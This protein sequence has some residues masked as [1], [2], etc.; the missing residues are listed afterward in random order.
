[1]NENYQIYEEED[2][3]SI[4]EIFEALLKRIKLIIISV[5]IFTLGVSFFVFFVSKPSYEAKVKI[6]AGKTEQVQS[7]YSDKELESYSAI[8]NTYIGLIKTE[9]F[10]SKIINKT[11]IDATPK[12]L[13]NSLQFITTEDTPI[14]EIKYQS[15]D[16][17]IAENVVRTV[18]EEFEISVKEVILNTYTRV[19]DSVKVAEVASGNATKLAIGVLLGLMVGCGL[20]FL[21]EYLDD[22]VNKKEKLETLLPIPILGELPLEEDETSRSKKTKKKKKR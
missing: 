20:A 1:M 16:P 21:L 19:I 9:D 11:G 17:Q 14:L 4:K 13:M 15:N 10:M 6:F 7:D 18:T 12:Q 22:T 8:M 3:M 2:V 5:L